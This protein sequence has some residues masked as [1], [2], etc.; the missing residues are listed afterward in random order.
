MVMITITAEVVKAARDG[1]TITPVARRAELVRG[2][3]SSGL[4]MESYH[5][6]FKR[7]VLAKPYV[8]KRRE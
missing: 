8:R 1:Q 7:E 2:Y 6:A 5:L 4:T 3:L